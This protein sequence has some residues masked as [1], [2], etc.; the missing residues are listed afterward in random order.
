ML[1]EDRQL[2]KAFLIARCLRRGS[3]CV[4]GM[5]SCVKGESPFQA[6]MV[7]T[8]A[9][10]KGAYREVRSG[11]SRMQ[12]PDPRNT[13]RIEGCDIRASLHDKAKPKTVHEGFTLILSK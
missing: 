8:V 12:S 11:G 1:H 4:P 5:N 3:S 7:E 9:E 10:G 6:L 13:N 2:A